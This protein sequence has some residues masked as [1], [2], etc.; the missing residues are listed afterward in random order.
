MHPKGEVPAAGPVGQGEPGAEACQEALPGHQV[1]GAGGRGWPGQ[2]PG[3]SRSACNI[4]SLV[5]E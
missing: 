4:F 2:E 1:A 3:G 5:A